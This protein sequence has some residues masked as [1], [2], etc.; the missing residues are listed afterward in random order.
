[1]LLKSGLFN[2]SVSLDLAHPW[3]PYS[4]CSKSC[5]G[6]QRSRSRN[7]VGQVACPSSGTEVQTVPCLESDCPGL[8][9]NILFFKLS[10]G[11]KFFILI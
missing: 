1:M 11:V 2:L 4:A 5:G 9:V 3:S 7:C 10:R 6:G 8:L